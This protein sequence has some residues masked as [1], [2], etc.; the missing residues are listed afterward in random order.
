MKRKFLISI[1][2]SLSFSFL[3]L[4]FAYFW[5]ESIPF[6]SKFYIWW[7]IIGIAILP[8]F[9]ML[10]V[11]I[12]NLLNNKIKSYPVTNQDTTILICAYNEEKNIKN[13]INSIL[14]Q[15]YKGHITIMVVD[16]N[17][18]DN[19]KNIVCEYTKRS[20]KNIKIKYLFCKEKGKYNALNMGLKNIKTKYFITLDADTLLQKNAIQNIINHIEKRKCGCVAGNLFLQNPMYSFITKI[21]IYDYILS[22]AAI[23][24]YQGS[25]KS[26]LVAQGAFSAFNTNAVKNIGGWK[27]N[28]GED[29]VLTYELLKSG[30]ISEYEPTA[31]GYTFAPQTLK[32][33]YHQRKRWAVGMLEGFKAVK[34]WQYPSKYTSF[35]TSI[36]ISIIYLDFA[37]ILGFIPGVIMALFGY[38]FFVGIYTLLSMI[39][40]VTM[41]L[42]IYLFQKN[43]NFPFKNNFIG[44]IG[45]LL[46]FQA[47]SSLASISAYIDVLISKKNFKWK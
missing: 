42:S 5:A 8:G 22:I 12:S 43:L 30:E 2:I 17:S 38:Y 13:T 34:P 45:F 27:E 6:F 3:S 36:N 11:F 33:L 39:I 29:I 47:I 44:F 41:Q 20:F 14:N 10:N 18:T 40:G 32:Q 1:F 25:Y 35:L 46:F 28:Y 16:N 15:E 9:L 7:V 4:I 26:T 24:R 23:K 19:T 31:L 21:Q 37:Y